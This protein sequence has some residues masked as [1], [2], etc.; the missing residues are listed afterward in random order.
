MHDPTG[1]DPTRGDPARGDPTRDGRAHPPAEAA[2]SETPRSRVSKRS[3]MK[4]AGWVDR[5]SGH[6][7]RHPGF[8]IRLGRLESRLIADRLE[9]IRVEKPVHVTGLARSGTTILLELLA[10]HPEAATHRYRDFPPVLVPWMWNRFLAYAARGDAV[11]TERAHGDRIMI[12]PESPEAFEEA[13]WMAFFP[14]AHDP[15]RSAVLDEAA[16]HP[17]FEAFYRDHVRK[18]LLVRGGRRYVAKGNYNVTRLGYIRTIFPDARFVIPVRDP[19]WHIASL[20][21]Q[22]ERFAGEGARDERVRRHMRRSGHYEFGLDRR[23]IHTGDDT[24]AERVRSLWDAGREIEGWATYWALV[25]RHVRVT[26]DGSPALR[27]ATMVVRYE[28]LCAEPEATVARVLA[29]CGLPAG[30]LPRVAGETIR[31]PDY[32][33]PS[34]DAAEVALIR[35]HT[36]DVARSFGYGD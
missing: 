28:E 29:H 12:T 15:M 36:D 24:G 20:M 9:D 4:V 2:P 35:H 6:I 34:F 31:A 10:R 22:H 11:A 5:L 32:Y 7:E 19:V 30:E 17:E 8:W 14:G 26:L 27:D 1:G 21:R 13:V 33:R 16:R 3:G 25:Y 23:P 18:L